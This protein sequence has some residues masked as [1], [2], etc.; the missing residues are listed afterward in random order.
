[1]SK[2]LVE[3]ITQAHDKDYLTLRMGDGSKTEVLAWFP[4]ERLE[5]RSSWTSMW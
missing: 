3:A 4:V 5:T 1:M 2:V